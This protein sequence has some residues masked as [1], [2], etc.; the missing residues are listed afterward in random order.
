MKRTQIQVNTEQLTWLKHHA[1]GKGVSMS[2]VVRESV[3]FYRAYIEK[4]QLRLQQRK[5]ALT[6][7][8]CFSSNPKP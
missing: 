6:A 4:S 7:V 5:N 1:V 8:G 3:D 2:Q